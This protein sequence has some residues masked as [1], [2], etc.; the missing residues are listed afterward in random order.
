MSK[1]SGF[2]EVHNVQLYCLS[3][4]A[5]HARSLAALEAGTL[6]IL[7]AK[8]VREHKVQNYA[9]V[10]VLMM[11]SCVIHQWNRKSVQINIFD[12]ASSTYGAE[13]P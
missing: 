4:A 2:S 13:R 3:C 7:R 11:G 10:A 1:V 12:G 9:P 8:I 6:R 5:L